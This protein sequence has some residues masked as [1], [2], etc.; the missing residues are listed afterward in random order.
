MMSSLGFCMGHMEYK[1]IWVSSRQIANII[2]SSQ[3]RKPTKIHQSQGHW[4]TWP[5]PCHSAC[6]RLGPALATQLFLLPLSLS[7]GA[8]HS[9]DDSSTPSPWHICQHTQFLTC[10]FTS[11]F[12]ALVLFPPPPSSEIPRRVAARPG[13][14]TLNMLRDGG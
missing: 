1:R 5:H 11:V 8:R 2:S 13:P 10:N 7:C 12:S 4:M 3:Q 6:P 9:Y 14:V